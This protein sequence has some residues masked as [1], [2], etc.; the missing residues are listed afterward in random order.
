MML[1]RNPPNLVFMVQFSPET[2]PDAG[3]MRRTGRVEHI[4]SGRSCRFAS[5][6]EVDDFMMEVLRRLSESS[7]PVTPRSDSKL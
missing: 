1:I 7:E 2:D 4:E 6:Q 5:M 3:R